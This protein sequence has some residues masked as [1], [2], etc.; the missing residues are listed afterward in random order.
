[1]VMNYDITFQD[2]RG[3][4]FADS[5][6]LWIAHNDNEAANDSV[7]VLSTYASVRLVAS[8]FNLPVRTVAERVH[9]LRTP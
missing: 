9:A 7:E 1:M 6:I 5:A 2:V 8:V 3:E 4:Y